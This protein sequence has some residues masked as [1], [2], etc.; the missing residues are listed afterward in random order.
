M[1]TPLYRRASSAVQLAPQDFH[2]QAEVQEA[3]VEEDILE[4][5]STTLQFSSLKDAI[6]PKTYNALTKAPFT[7][8]DMT[9]VQNAVLSQLPELAETSKD[10]LVKAKTGTGKTIA[11]LVPA[12]EARLNV[13]KAAAEKAE[14]HSG[15]RDERMSYGADEAYARKHVGT[16]LSLIHI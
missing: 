15:M 10:L 4:D 1:S 3:D 6:H 14:H 12:T 2:S 16:L 9:P 7:Y 13:L 5:G 8:V 11:F